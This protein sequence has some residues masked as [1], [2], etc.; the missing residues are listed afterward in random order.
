MADNL[1]QWFVYR[2]NPTQDVVA[3]GTLR[4]GFGGADL[5]QIT[6][7]ND[8]CND[9]I[10]FNSV[11]VGGASPNE[12]YQFKLKIFN[13][14]GNDPCHIR[15]N[16]SAGNFDFTLEYSGAPPAGE[17]V[18][19]FQP[20][21]DWGITVISD[22]TINAEA[23]IG[24]LAGSCV[25]S[26][27]C[28]EGQV[29][30]DG[31][32]VDCESGQADSFR[33]R[34]EF[35]ELINNVADQVPSYFVQTDPIDLPFN[36]TINL[37]D[38]GIYNGSNPQY[39]YAR[40]IFLKD[41][42]PA[43]YKTTSPN[44]FSLEL[45]HPN[46]QEVPVL[47]YFNDA[48]AGEKF[49]GS[50]EL[51]LVD[52][53]QWIFG[54]EALVDASV[55]EEICQDVEVPEVPEPVEYEPIEP[56]PPEDE[57]PPIGTEPPIPPEP[58]DPASSCDCEVYLGSV[59]YNIFGSIPSLIGWTIDRICAGISFWLRKQNEEI[60][61]QTDTFKFHMEKLTGLFSGYIG[62]IQDPNQKTINELIQEMIDTINSRAQYW[63]ND[64]VVN[65][66][67]YDGT[68]RTDGYKQARMDNF[69]VLCID[70]DNN[71]KLMTFNQAVVSGYK[72]LIR[73]NGQD[74]WVRFHQET[75]DL[76]GEGM[77]QGYN[78]INHELEGAPLDDVEVKF[79]RSQKM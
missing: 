62:A 42:S 36:G 12:Q 26:D 58:I 22:L 59:I 1:Y 13:Q 9:C 45:R 8:S 33:I 64:N 29:C 57:Q 55:S 4:T 14:L 2:D 32:C 67:Y 39:A 56:D 79:I 31:N 75:I 76:I 30:I 23:I 54:I 53:Q 21:P 43:C 74:K 34:L 15:V 20:I 65:Y 16:L 24:E 70:S 27:E 35:P 7:H 6:I 19:D 11:I 78:Q 44:G 28:P 37:P 61:Y 71:E 25:N 72:I 5:N 46:G 40:I 66:L 63:E 18:V 52:V 77:H 51:Q 69:H 10:D 47:D 41:G 38:V 48:C 17:N 60:R 73:E 3:Q 49:Y 68:F 50:F